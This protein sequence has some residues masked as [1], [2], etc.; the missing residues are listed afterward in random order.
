MSS[1]KRVFSHEDPHDYIDYLKLKKGE[2]LL[3]NKKTKAVDPY[4]NRF[5]SYQDFLAMTNA[6]YKHK[7]NLCI[8]QPLT[9]LYNTNK[10]FIPY[11][12]LMEHVNSCDYCSKKKDCCFQE[13]TCEQLKNILYPYGIYPTYCEPTIYF[14]NQIN[15]NEWCKKQTNICDSNHYIDTSI[16]NKHVDPPTNENKNIIPCGSKYGICKNTKPLFI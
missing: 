8:F 9:N 2:T 10:S 5:V 12:K 14:P 4:L 15:L 6:Y 3:Q 11:E 7:N 13:L 16:C 1:K